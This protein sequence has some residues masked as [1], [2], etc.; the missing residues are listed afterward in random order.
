MFQTLKCTKL[1][2]RVC[3]ENVGTL[4]EREGRFFLVTHSKFLNHEK[5][6]IFHVRT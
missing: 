2:N 3:G 6:I 5:S 1:E 4:A